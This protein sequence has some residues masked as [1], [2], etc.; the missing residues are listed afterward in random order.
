[1]AENLFFGRLTENGTTIRELPAASWFRDLLQ[2]VDLWAPLRGF[3]ARLVEDLVDER[4]NRFIPTRKMPI[5]AEEMPLLHRT[6]DRLENTQPGEL[7]ERQQRMLVGIA[8]RY[9]PA[10]H[11][12]SEPPAELAARIVRLRSRVKR[13]MTEMNRDTVDCYHPED[14]IE[15]ASIRTNI[16]FGQITSRDAAAVKRIDTCVNRLLVEGELLETIVAIGMRHRVGRAGENLSG[17]QRQ[18]LALA[19]A[20]LKK[21]SI[22]LL[23]EATASLDNESQE[24]VQKTLATRWKGKATLVAV[25]HRLDIITHFDR[26]AVMESGQIVEMGAFE[27]LMDLKGRL[28]QLV[29]KQR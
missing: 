9:T 12:L 26:I 28:Y 22:L 27:E 25:V 6:A 29:Q 15:S 20:L 11:L 18:K 5:T 14:Y 4:G 24:R 21:P 23:D 17:G 2:E 7:T 8:L 19:R 10:D 13:V 1:M 16:V 3:G